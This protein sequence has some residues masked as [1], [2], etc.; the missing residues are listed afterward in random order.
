MKILAIETSC[1]DTC[2]AIL[3][4]YKVLSHA[5]FTQE[6]F[7]QQST[8]VIP[9]IATQQHLKQIDKVIAVAVANAKIKLT[10]ID[11]VAYTHEPGLK[12]SLFVG[13]VAAQAIAGFSGAKLLPLNHLQG[14]TFSIMANC[15]RRI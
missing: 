3:N 2:C 1:D 5:R 13:A 9:Q 14:H 10:D 7:Y 6:S 15:K 12:P 4:N 11:F 8:G